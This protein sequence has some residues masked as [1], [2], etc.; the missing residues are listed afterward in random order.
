[1]SRIYCGVGKVPKN[2]ILGSMK[3]CQAKKQI[4]LYGLL[5]VDK[6]LL[7]Q[8]TDMVK[9]KKQRMKALKNFYTYKGR[10]RRLRGKVQAAKGDKKIKAQKELDEVMNLVK[11]Y[12]KELKEIEKLKP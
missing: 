7:K 3:D 9:Y 2:A 8:R 4:R 10:E 6:Q 12:A 1:M 11:K 5:K